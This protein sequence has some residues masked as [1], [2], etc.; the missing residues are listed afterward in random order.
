[1]PLSCNIPYGNQEE[2]E[3]DEVVSHASGPK[4]WRAKYVISAYLAIVAACAG[5]G[6]LGKDTELDRKITKYLDKGRFNKASDNENLKYVRDVYNAGD[7]LLA[8]SLASTMIENGKADEMIADLSD[9]EMYIQL[10]LLAQQLAR[11]NPS[12]VI[13]QL[14]EAARQSHTV[15]ADVI[16]T[17]ERT[18]VASLSSKDPNARIVH[19]ERLRCFI[20]DSPKGDD[21]SIPKPI[22]TRHA[23][24][25]AAQELVTQD[26]AFSS[27]LASKACQE[28]KNDPSG[29]QF[30]DE[31]TSERNIYSNALIISFVDQM[32][33][34]LD[35]MDLDNAANTASELKTVLFGPSFDLDPVTATK[36]NIAAEML[37]VKGATHREEG[38]GKTCC[39]L[40][41]GI[42]ETLAQLNRKGQSEELASSN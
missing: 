31:T 33:K 4:T 35:V 18:F 25:H 9:R 11:E 2:D 23:Y 1:M 14:V 6:L 13:D 34:Y 27:I 12:V 38:I 42:K 17:R 28:R 19:A 5:V 36:L 20:P 30:L 37:G 29:Q 39:I 32:S 10:A 26:P 16:T 40:A 22:E 8:I 15:H 21:T 7:Y 24:W 41:D 3:G